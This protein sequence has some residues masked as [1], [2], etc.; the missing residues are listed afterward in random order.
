MDSNPR[1]SDTLAKIDAS[2]E[3]LTEVLRRTEILRCHLGIVADT[4]GTRLYTGLVGADTPNAAPLTPPLAQRLE[5]IHT[6]LND[7]GTA[8]SAK[9][10]AMIYQLE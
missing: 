7:T 9:I 3:F 10:S 1:I 8:L 6:K 5:K 2:I 4:T